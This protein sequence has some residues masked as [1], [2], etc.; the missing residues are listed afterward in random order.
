MSRRRPAS[1]VVR[2]TLATTAILAASFALTLA[3]VLRS[4]STTFVDVQAERVESAPLSAS[5]ADADGDAH[6]DALRRTLEEAFARGGWEE[7]RAAAADPSAAGLGSEVAFLA[8]EA[9]TLRVAAATDPAWLLARATAEPGGGLTVRLARGGDDG[10]RAEL[11]IGSDAPVALG[12]WGL[13]L[14]LPPPPP[15]PAVGPRFAVRVWRAAAVGLV[16]VVLLAVVAT[17]WILRRALAPVDRLTRAARELRDGRIPE[18]LPSEGTREIGALVD[19]FNAAAESVDRTERLRKRLIADVAHELRTPVTNLKGQLEA[20]EAGL[21][22]PDAELVETLQAE[23]RL[24]ERLVE[25]FQQL[26]L[27]DAGALRLDVQT[28]PLAETLR[29]IL[30]PLAEAAGAQLAVDA[31]GDLAVRADEERLRQILA[32][33]T[34]NAA[35][36]RPEGLRLEVVARADGAFAAVELRDN[37]PG[38]APEHRPHIFER[39]YRADPSR[40]RA[41]GGAGLGLAIAQGLAEAMGGSLRYVAREEGGAAFELRLPR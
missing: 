34:D 41:T 27:S 18:R 22:R 37:G 13:L 26:A 35:R 12:A 32:N 8:V 10:P 24:L 9:D 6:A 31:P 29:G 36:H 40:S 11:E 15:D 17:A 38:V 7:V 19:A 3:L 30:R 14:P 39:F 1:L 4:A 25:D 16:A 23:T 5:G 33:L 28:L 2:L 21:I 20:L